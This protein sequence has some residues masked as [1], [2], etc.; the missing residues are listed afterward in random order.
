MVPRYFINVLYIN[1]S[2]VSNDRDEKRYMNNQKEWFYQ[3]LPYERER[4]QHEL[5]EW[6]SLNST[7]SSWMAIPTPPA[8]TW[9]EHRQQQYAGWGYH[10]GY[11][12]YY[13]NSQVRE[14]QCSRPNPDDN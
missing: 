1:V 10:P 14:C 6:N 9:D 12:G 2:G 8:E 4:Y 13:T 11:W 3:N 7:R 5:K